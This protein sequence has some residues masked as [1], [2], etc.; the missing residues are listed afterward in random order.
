MPTNGS[1]TPFAPTLRKDPP[2]NSGVTDPSKDN[3]HTWMNIASQ[4]EYWNISPEV[5]LSSFARTNTDISNRNCATK[6]TSRIA[7]RP[8]LH[9][10]RA[11]QE[12]LHL[13]RSNSSLQQEVSELALQL[14]LSDSKTLHLSVVLPSPQLVCLALQNLLPRSA[15]LRHLHSVLRRLPLL[16]A[17][18]NKTPSLPQMRSDHL[19]LHS[20][21]SQCNLLLVCLVVRL[22]QHR[23]AV[24]SVSQHNLLHPR[25]R[26][27]A[28]LVLPLLRQNQEDL[29]SEL[30]LRNLLPTLSVKLLLQ[31][32]SLS[33]VSSH[34]FR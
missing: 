7:R 2:G 10:L 11:R 30:L 4:K 19:L 6:T 33:V 26:S 34:V 21:N 3:I 27:V 17:L 28:D 29:L 5:I 14:Q 32:D 8:L 15:H 16:S 12:A 1:S 9:Q 18:V 20:A 31:P 24:C 23:R 13:A 25:Q 22:S